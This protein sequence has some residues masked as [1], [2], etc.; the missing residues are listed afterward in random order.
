VEKLFGCPSCGYRCNAD[1]NASVNLHRVFCST[2][3][4]V[5]KVGKGK[6]KLNGEVIDLENVRKAWETAYRGLASPF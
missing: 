5:R 2:F 3:P 1:F 4:D 6:V